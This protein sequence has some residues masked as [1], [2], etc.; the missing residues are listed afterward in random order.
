MSPSSAPPPQA[1][2]SSKR[3]AKPIPAT[4]PSSQVSASVSPNSPSPRKLAL[5]SCFVPSARVSPYFPQATKS[6]PSPN[7]PAPFTLA[8][9]T[10]SPLQR[11]SAS[12]A[13]NRCL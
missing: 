5:Q 2:T 10:T 6:Y 9:A 1:K 13:A 3:E 4:S 8:T 7:N 11:K 12:Q